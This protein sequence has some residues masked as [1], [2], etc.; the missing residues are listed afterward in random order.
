[1]LITA[2]IIKYHAIDMPLIDD[3]N[4]ISLDSESR[5]I[6]S[7]L[8]AYLKIADSLDRSHKQKLSDFKIVLNN[9]TLTIM[10]ETSQDVL[11]EEWEYENKS[12]LFRQ[13]YGIKP[14]LI[15]KRK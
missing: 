13:V 10:A 2:N 12:N 15:I 1:M 11:L 9:F 4:Y 5:I 14:N 6:I 8:A 3:I 7:K